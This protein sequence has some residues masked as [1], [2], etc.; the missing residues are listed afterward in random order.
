M[1][2]QEQFFHIFI[3]VKILTKLR[4][5]FC[6]QRDEE[7]LIKLNPKYNC[8]KIPLETKC[9]MSDLPEGYLG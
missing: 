7:I 1:Y 8:N 5:I 4:E 3:F 6:V 2:L 9:K